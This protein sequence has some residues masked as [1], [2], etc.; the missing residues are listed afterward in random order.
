MNESSVKKFTKIFKALADTSRQKIML[1]LRRKGEMSVGDIVR[2]LEL[3]QPTVSQHLRVLK[4]AGALKS[5][6]LGQEIHYSV[7][8]EMI[9]DVMTAFLKIYKVKNKKL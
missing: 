8:N 2:E 4:E 1:H 6:R 5:R 9:C 3:A 7:C